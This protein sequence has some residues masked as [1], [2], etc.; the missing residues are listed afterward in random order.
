MELEHRIIKL[1]LKVDDHAEELKKLQD[2]SSD[3]RKS[4]A[5]IEKT[6]AQI[7]YLAMG[8]VAVVVAQSVGIDK[9]IKLFI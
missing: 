5:G 9:A 6:L 4:L 1:E 8:A 3:L 7:K 2:I